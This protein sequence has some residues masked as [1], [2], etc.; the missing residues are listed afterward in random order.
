MRFIRQE[1][2]IT[3]ICNQEVKKDEHISL[4]LEKLKEEGVYFSLSVKKMFHSDYTDHIITHGKVKVK[5]VN[6]E[7]RKVNFIV[8][9]ETSLFMINNVEFDD[10]LEI[11]AL[12]KKTNLLD[13]IKN[14]GFFDFIDLDE[15]SK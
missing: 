14:K 12:T 2:I 8:F 9:K 7:E 3:T 10:I 13:G 6:S 1:E 5:N 15:E 4:V 11:F